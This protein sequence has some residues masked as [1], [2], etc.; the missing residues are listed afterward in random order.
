M[1]KCTYCGQELNEAQYKTGSDGKDYKSC[2]CC[3]VND[4]SEHI[5]YPYPSSF[6]T[7]PFRKT[8]NHPDGPQSYCEPCRGGTTGPHAGY[9]KCSAV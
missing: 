4:G 6:G 5:F 8:P 9:K 2:P 3:S 1:A 7:T